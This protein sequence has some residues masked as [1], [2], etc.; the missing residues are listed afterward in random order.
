MSQIS[1][2]IYEINNLKKNYND[3][4]VINIRQLKFHRGTI[5]GIVGPIGSGKSTLLKLMAGYIKQTDGSI[6]YEN[7]S[8]ETNLFGKIKHNPEIKLVQLDD[9][10]DQSKLSGLLD[11]D[12][13]DIIIPRYLKKNNLINYKNNVDNFS[14]GERA[15]LNLTIAFK[16]DPRVLLIDDYGILFDDEIEK[17]LRNK[18]K[19]INK[20]FGTTIILSS[21]NDTII[22]RFASVLLYLNNGHLSKIRSKQSNENKSR[23]ISSRKKPRPRP[24]TRYSTKK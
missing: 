7:E 5:Y 10:L 11:N 9:K 12:F 18:I 20:E 17:D 2:L 15:L 6:N 23:K 22:K 8:F 13:S 21:P 16:E 1:S 4:E 19:Y 14:K 24:R 3:R